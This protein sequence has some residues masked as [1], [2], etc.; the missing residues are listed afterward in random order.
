VQPA[1]VDALHAPRDDRDLRRDPQDDRVQ[2]LSRLVVVLLGV[3]QRAQVADVA[4]GEALEVEEDARGDEW[5]RQAAA[6]CLV[7]AGD[8]A[9]AEP[10]VVPEEATARG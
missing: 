10:A 2:R 5:T 1:R 6:A 8:E 9:V 7:S 3:V 4:P